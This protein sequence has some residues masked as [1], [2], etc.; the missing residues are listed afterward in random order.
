MRILHASDTAAGIPSVLASEQR[1]LGH[2]AHS[3]RYADHPFGYQSDSVFAAWA[4]AGRLEKLRLALRTT[5]GVSLR[6]DVF[7]LTAGRTLLPFMLDLP[8]L[9]AL[10]R[11]IVVHFHGCEVRHVAADRKQRDVFCH[12]CP[13]RPACRPR[14]QQWRR[15]MAERFADVMLCSTPDLL[16]AV[17]R[18]HYVPNPIDL[19]GWRSNGQPREAADGLFTVVHAPSNP[20]LKG[21]EY[22]IR[23]VDD[24]RRAGLPIQLRLVTGV[25]HEQVHAVYESADLVVDQLLIGW[26]GVA[27]IEAMALRKPVVAYL[28]PG[29]AQRYGRPPMLH[30]T[31]ETLKAVLTGALEARADLS[32]LA[33]RGHAYVGATHDARRVAT[34][35]LDLYRAARAGRCAE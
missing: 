6:Y 8:L 13:V 17:P 31:P 1:R 23:A 5:V 16:Q 35:L 10:N 29:L 3:L 14:L 25:P 33:D 9:K 34:D 15:R 27:A 12:Q 22:V 4:A 19:R 21:T 30:A 7:H 26:Y 24:L 2:V 28:E 32:E 18:A 11:T 20:L